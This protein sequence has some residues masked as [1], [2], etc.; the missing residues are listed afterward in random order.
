MRKY[1]SAAL[2]TLGT[3]GCM[4]AVPQS[5]SAAN[6]ILFSMVRS[7][8]VENAG[9]ALNATARVTV[10]SLGPVEVM[11][12]EASGLP[13]NQEFDLFVIQ[14]PN[15]PFGMAWYQGD[16]ESNAKG[17][18]VGDF[19]GRFNNETFI[20]APGSVPAPVVHHSTPFPDAA[21]NPVTAPIHTFHIGLW[22]GTP[23]AAV[24][25]GC[26]N[27]QTPFNGDHTAGIQVLST[28]NFTVNGPLRSL[29]P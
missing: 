22:F 25:A 23:D 1:V 18:A 6:S 8:A 20:V 28:R 10:N 29:A 4:L 7:A 5:A 21:T 14:Q 13:P 12:V 2:G 16:M 19:V 26:P 27:T 15:N 17:R 9:C 24:A 11:H 3:I